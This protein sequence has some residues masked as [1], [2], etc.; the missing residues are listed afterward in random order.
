M[1]EKDL[2]SNTVALPE[3]EGVK[4]NPSTK[5]AIKFPLPPGEGEGEGD[6]PLT[7]SHEASEARRRKP[8]MLRALGISAF[9]RDSRGPE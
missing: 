6:D 4:P 1:P 8:G 2:I 7:P 9:H 3:G 5:A